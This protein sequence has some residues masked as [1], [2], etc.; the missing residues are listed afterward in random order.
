MVV[1]ALAGATDLLLDDVS[2][3]DIVC[4]QVGEGC[5]V[6]FP[7]QQRWLL[8]QAKRHL[9]M[10]PLFHAGCQRIWDFF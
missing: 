5:N 10:N 1:F 4:L 3:V 6:V 2:V 8:P 9:P 7:S